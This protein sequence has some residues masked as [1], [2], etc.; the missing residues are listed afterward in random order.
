VAMLEV[1]DELF[2]QLRYTHAP[3]L[4]CMA[5]RHYEPLL[6]P[7]YNM[8]HAVAKRSAQ[9]WQVVHASVAA[10]RSSQTNTKITSARG[11]ASPA[12]PA[13]IKRCTLFEPDLLRPLVCQG[14]HFTLVYL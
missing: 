11:A 13:T 9:Q 14:S 10:S 12:S 2:A 1:A 6:A 3:S 8:L 4:A 5:M 7:S